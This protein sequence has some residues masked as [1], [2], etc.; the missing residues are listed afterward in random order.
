MLRDRTNCGTG[1]QEAPD[2]GLL[3]KKTEIG[4]TVSYVVNVRRA[5][6]TMFAKSPFVSKR[7][8]Q[9]ANNI[10]HLR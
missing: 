2:A 8:T 5:E 4:V 3:E 1:Q 6:I 10:F 9:N 7:A